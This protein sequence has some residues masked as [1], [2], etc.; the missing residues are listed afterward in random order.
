MVELSV[1]T[2]ICWQSG[3]TVPT[4]SPTAAPFLL[5]PLRVVWFSYVVWDGRVAVNA[6]AVQLPRWTARCLQSQTGTT[7]VMAALL[8]RLC[9]FLNTCIV[10]C[11]ECILW[12]VKWCNYYFCNNFS[13][14]CAAFNYS[15]CIVFQSCWDVCDLW[16]TSF[17]MRRDRDAEREETWGLLSPHHLTK[18]LRERP[19]LS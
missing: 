19:K 15:F 4:E 7:S 18:G 8:K 11:F 5:W 2:V 6:S 13:K 1:D 16:T 12:S 9:C 10:T 17:R 14:M 3:T